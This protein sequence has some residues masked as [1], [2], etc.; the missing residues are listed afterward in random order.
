MLTIFQKG[1]AYSGR[2]HGGCLQYSTS[3][4]RSLIQVVSRLALNLVS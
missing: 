2:D 1:G 4:T 3:A